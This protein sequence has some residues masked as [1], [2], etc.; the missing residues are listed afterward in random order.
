MVNVMTKKD[1]LARCANAY[2][3]GLT[4]GPILRHLER[5]YDA[6]FRLEGDQFRYFVDWVASEQER[7]RHFSNEYQLANDKLGYNVVQ[8]LAVLTHPCQK[9]AVDPDAWH[10][11][12]AF[13]SHRE[14]KPIGFA[15]N[16]R[17]EKG[18]LKADVTLTKEG[19]KLRKGVLE[20]SQ[21]KV[22]CTKHKLYHGQKYPS[23]TPNPNHVKASKKL[24][25]L[26]KESNYGTTKLEK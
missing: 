23:C 15:K 11:R 1:F 17:V 25:K 22:Y 4:Q 24:T 20:A 10:T 12:P 19:Q 8:L 5:A 21:L 2:N 16:I 9:C 6:L 3:M 26:F 14:D 18:I 13:C 7:T